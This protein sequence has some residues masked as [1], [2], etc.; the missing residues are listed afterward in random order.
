MWPPES[1]V[2]VDGVSVAGVGASVAGVVASAVVEPALGSTVSGGTAPTLSSIVPGCA[3]EMRSAAA[4]T[5]PI[6]SSVTATPANGS[7]VRGFVVCVVAVCG[8]RE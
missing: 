4:G 8:R 1:W 5:P 6:V 2:E 7:F 3:G